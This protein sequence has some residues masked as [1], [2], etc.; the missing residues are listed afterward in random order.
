MQS[1]QREKEIVL[2]GIGHTNAHVLRMW[3]T[4]PIPNAR[5]TCVSNFS[6]AT[7]S[8]MLPGVLAGQY[9]RERMEIDLGRLCDAAGAHFV[10]ADARGLD[11]EARRLLFEDRAPLPFDVLSIGIG[12]MPTMQGVHE[13]DEMVVPIKP[14][15][16]FVPR[17]ESRLQSV[18]PGVD[19]RPL[20]VAVVG[21]G[22]AGVEITFCLAPRVTMVLGDVQ[23]EQL[24]ITADE[25]LAPGTAN[26]T[27]RLIE[28]ELTR[29]RVE[30]V[31]GRRVQRA[32]GGA[33]E[34][35]DGTKL[36]AD[37]ALWATG[38]GAPPLLGQMNLPRDERGFLLTRPT[39][40][41][42][43]DAPVFAVGD[44]GTIEN[45]HTPKA[46]VFAVRQAPVLWKNIRRLLSG[47]RLLEYRPQRNFLK[48]INTGDGRAIAEYHGVSLHNRLMWWLKDAIDSRFIAK[49]QC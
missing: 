42:T 46:G 6:V 19:G 36:E 4:E 12:S 1:S 28:K 17:L 14:M 3:R 2:L 5:L 33:V 8:G 32:T 35:D 45:S 9:R 27:R 40:R 47:E 31:F 39:L 21:G 25:E 29:R 26:S 16:T 20:R 44:T 23:L 49:Y 15:Q 11:V 41:T 13:T 48:L 43:A 30:T 38:A 34:L 22:V 10:A 24:L 18:A 37:V 7:Y